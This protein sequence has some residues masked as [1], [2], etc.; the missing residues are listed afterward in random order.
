MNPKSWTQQKREVYIDIIETFFTNSHLNIAYLPYKMIEAQNEVA[1]ATYDKNIVCLC[2]D[3]TSFKNYM[4][5]H[6]ILHTLGLRHS[7]YEQEEESNIYKKI[8][9]EQGKTENLMDYKGDKYSTF[10]WQWEQIYEKYKDK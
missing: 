2:G 1:W 3:P 8:M 5:A 6:E 9:Y 7:F 10:K 4:L